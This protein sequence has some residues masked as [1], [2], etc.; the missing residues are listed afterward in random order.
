MGHQKC[1]RTSHFL[2]FYFHFLK[3]F[4]TQWISQ[5]PRKTHS[6]TKK[7]FEIELT[8]LKIVGETIMPSTYNGTT[9][10]CRDNFKLS[11][12]IRQFKEFSFS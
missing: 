8:P 12:K 4:A 5:T 11:S 2:L 9:G 10:N 7:H 6:R 1:W 3:L